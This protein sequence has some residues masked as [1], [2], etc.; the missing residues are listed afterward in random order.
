MVTAGEQEQFRLANG[1]HEEANGVRGERTR[2]Q[3]RRRTHPSYSATARAACAIRPGQMVAARGSSLTIICSQRRLAITSTCLRFAFGRS[4]KRLSRVRGNRTGKGWFR[5]GPQW[6]PWRPAEKPSGIRSF[7]G[8]SYN[9]GE[10]MC[11]RLRT[12]CAA[13]DWP[14]AKLMRVF[15]INST[16]L[17]AT[18]VNRRIIYPAGGAY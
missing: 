11:R 8:K 14:K 3:S 9:A 5:K 15:A 10:S 1:F 12:P 17:C 7:F 4:V 13:L 16:L 18:I 6:K 2:A